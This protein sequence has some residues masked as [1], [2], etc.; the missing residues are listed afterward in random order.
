MS[1]DDPH[2]TPLRRPNTLNDSKS[3]TRLESPDDGSRSR[4]RASTLTSVAK[5]LLPQNAAVLTPEEEERDAQGDV[6]NTAQDEGADAEDP[7]PVA[8][9]QTFEELPIEIRS[10]TERFLES[11]SAKV[12]PTPPS[13]DTLSDLFQDFYSK[14][15]TVIATHIATLSSR[16]SRDKSPAPS[17]SSKGSKLSR[18]GAG[19]S[20]G[21]S[22]SQNGGSGEQQLLTPSEVFDRR[23]ARKLLE[24]KK[25]ALEETVER[26]ACEKVY[27]RIYRHRSTDDE[28]RDEKLRSRTAALSLVGIGLKELLVSADNVPEE[29]MQMAAAEEDQ[30]NGW[31]QNARESIQLM[32]EER[33]PLGK[34]Q[35]LTA[36]H[37]S[38]VETLSKIFPSTS[39]ADE[40]LPTLIY[41]L[42]ISPP[43][44]L[45]VISNLNFIQRFRSSSK[46]DGEAAYCL[47]N[48]EAAISFLET[49]DLSS[50]RADEV[51]QGPGK[52][53][54]IPST[55]RNEATFTPMK[56]GISPAADPSV[57]N[58]DGARESLA[59]QLSSPISRAPPR[60]FSQLIQSQTNRLEAASD[61]LRGAVLENAE[62]GID[63][64]NSTLENS[65]KFLFGKLRE[66]QQQQNAD[67]SQDTT[68]IVP[69][70]LE[71]ARKLVNTSPLS[72]M[73]DASVSAAS[74]HTEDIPDDAGSKSDSKVLDLI[75][76]RQQMRDRSADSLRSLGSNKKVAF[77]DSRQATPSRTVS[78]SATI[79]STSGY[80]APQPAGGTAI[81]SVRNFGNSINPLNRLTGMGIFGRTVSSGSPS[82]T[83]TPSPE[84][85]KQLSPE[86]RSIT[87]K[88]L[89]TI[90][91]IEEL[92]KT[93]PPVKRFLEL[94]DARD[95]RVAEIDELLKEYQR[96]A[97]ALRVAISSS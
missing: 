67:S 96:L 22:L 56:L 94:K 28:E 93:P 29:A 95:M 25:N 49:V 85:R 90:A 63:T 35:H 40:V 14:A 41:T 60:R 82:V 72:D 38:I 16:I 80:I 4:G 91:T 32:N 9:P 33:Y 97:T 24:L 55:P 84:Q 6:F 74:S 18:I 51:P 69:K 30:I 50:L 45:N 70:T 59:K 92:K 26:A 3:F 73:D 5:E 86:E 48:L 11:L 76:G 64:I 36:V 42:I 1:Q 17:S 66:Q 23:K 81:D 57:G 47:V 44:S 54:S 37:R 75:G 83:V 68:I 10:L 65:F 27:D 7:P 61:S 8:F 62:K 21:S 88:E 78:E 46:L 31:L 87:A 52:V 71:D 20:R 79:G 2:D 39:S 34:L 58:E 53:N 12:H 15:E 13:A 43:A 19:R 89:K 77:A